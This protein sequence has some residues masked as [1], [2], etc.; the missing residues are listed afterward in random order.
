MHATS[1]HTH[2]LAIIFLF[3]HKILLEK[4]TEF[5]MQHTHTY[6]NKYALLYVYITKK[7]I[8]THFICMH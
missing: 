3:I 2:E 4:S 8:L 1:L 7:K 6:I 5:Y